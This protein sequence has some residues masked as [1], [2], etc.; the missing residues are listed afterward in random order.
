MNDDPGC[1]YFINMTGT[2]YLKIGYTY[3]LQR[4]FRQLQNNV[5]LPLIVL[6]QDWTY[7]PQELERDYHLAFKPFRLKSGEWFNIPNM[8]EE[9]SKYRNMFAETYNVKDEIFEYLE[10]DE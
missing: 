1:V 6:G 5:P 3:N 4:R 10:F 2:N 8:I 7:Q 9:I